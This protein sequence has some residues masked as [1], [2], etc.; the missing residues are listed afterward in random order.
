MLFSNRVF[1]CFL[2][3]NELKMLQF[4]LE[5]LYESVDYFVLVESTKGF[6]GLDK[7]LVFKENSHLFERFKKKI[8]HI[9][10]SDLQSEVDPWINEIHQRNQIGRGLLEARPN[11]LIFISDVD[12]IPDKKSFKRINCR[13]EQFDMIVLMQDMYYY[14]LNNYVSRWNA[15]RALSYGSFCKFDQDAHEIRMMNL[16]KVNACWEPKGGWHFSY[17]GGVEMILEKINNFSHQEFNNSLVTKE[18][19][20]DSISNHKDLFDRFPEKISS[21]CEANV[22]TESKS[23]MPEKNGLLNQLFEP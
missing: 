10:V 19:I 4:R 14:N 11:D 17:F 6:T 20:K 13:I 21:N 2:F 1:D 22:F 5:E 23:Y 9:I 18:K 15:A 7:M 12:E 8:I 16:K 3:F